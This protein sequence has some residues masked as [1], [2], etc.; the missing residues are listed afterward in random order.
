M[1]RT[2][3]LILFSTIGFIINM[4]MIANASAISDDVYNGTLESCKQFAAT[5][6]NTCADQST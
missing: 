2:I 3:N 5:F 4:K 1:K 6:N